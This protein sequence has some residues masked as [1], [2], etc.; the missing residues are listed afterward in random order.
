M[1]DFQVNNFMLVV[2]NDSFIV[3]LLTG[4]SVS[5]K[6]ALKRMN[7][8]SS[9]SNDT[10]NSKCK[11][12]IIDLRLLD[13]SLIK[14]HLGLLQNIHKKYRIPICALD[15]HG[16]NSSHPI[17]T[18][19]DEYI[20]QSFVEKLDSYINKNII[21]LSSAYSEK[22]QINRRLSADR[23]ALPTLLNSV[24]DTQN[25]GNSKQ[26]F[27]GLERN[28]IGD[29]EIDYSCRTV[30]LKGKDLE[31]TC[32]EFNLFILLAEDFEQVC[33]TEKI[34]K[35]LWPNTQRANKSDLYQYMHLLRK[36]V[37][38]FPDNT[39]WIQTIKGVG[40]KLQTGEYTPCGADSLV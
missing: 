24:S 16:A 37:E 40:Y 38:Q 33:T 8:D 3:G 13:S 14:I 12:I 10:V 17:P 25:K 18:W 36:K 27:K 22:R 34:I 7:S 21:N 19:I 26:F 28:A 1:T 39:H 2:S 23:R 30:F 6:F 11:S 35:H 4:Y 9:L 31:L 15:S 20:N 29:F 32:K 5:N